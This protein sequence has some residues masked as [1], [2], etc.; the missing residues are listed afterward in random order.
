MTD[1]LPMI[2][3]SSIVTPINFPLGGYGSLVSVEPGPMNTFFP[4]LDSGVI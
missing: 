1:L 3:L 2:A 4:I